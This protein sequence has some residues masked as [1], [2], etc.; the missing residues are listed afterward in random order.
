MKNSI[1]IFLFSFMAFTA[2]TISAQV[3]QTPSTVNM[4]LSNGSTFNTAKID[5]IE[6]TLSISEFG[7]HKVK[8]P[9]VD[10]S[11]SFDPSVRQKYF[12]TV[13]DNK[14]RI[15]FTI[16][17]LGKVIEKLSQ[18]DENYEPLFTISK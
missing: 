2:T 16:T 17:I 6:G 14:E 10:M 9:I 1:I 8:Y 18:L 5:M 12:V 11:P 4:S 15:D 7:A 3:A 13:K